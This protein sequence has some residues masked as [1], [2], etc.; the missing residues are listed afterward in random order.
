MSGEQAA[1]IDSIDN[2]LCATGF[3]RTV[4]LGE[5]GLR[6]TTCVRCGALVMANPEYPGGMSPV[7]VHRQWHAHLGA[8]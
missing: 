5:D 3:T 2:Y 8:L 1:E 7:D 6:A 4:A